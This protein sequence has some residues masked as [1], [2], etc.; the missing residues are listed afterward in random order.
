MPRQK[1]YANDPVKH[2]IYNS[3]RN[4]RQCCYNPNN[5]VYQRCQRNGIE[6]HCE[7]ERFEDFY[8]WV[9]E[10]L[11][12]PPFDRARIV[13]KDQ[14]KPFTR[15]NLEWNTHYE[16]GQRQI[17]CHHIRWRGKTLNIKQWAETVGV[18]FHTV[19]GRWGRGI[20]DPKQLFS[21]EKLRPT[22]AA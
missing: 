4:M 21:K 7:W 22:H 11:G 14:A 9:M 1:L 6:L 5:D 8:N 17:Q 12:P 3:Y 16:Q 20:T 19:Y 15:R 13:R 18:S 2:R 10:K